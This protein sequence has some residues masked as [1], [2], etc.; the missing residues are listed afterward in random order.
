MDSGRRSGEVA[1]ETAGPETGPEMF[2]LLGPE[3][4]PELLAPKSLGPFALSALTISLT[5]P[6]T[7]DATV[8]RLGA[9]VVAVPKLPTL[10]SILAVSFAPLLAPGSF[11][12]ESCAPVASGSVLKWRSGRKKS[13]LAASAKLA[14]PYSCR[15]GKS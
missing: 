11:G 15:R 12:N 6:L 9:V 3:M 14:S 8:P 7:M 4:G 1:P 2:E 10:F 13:G 5:M